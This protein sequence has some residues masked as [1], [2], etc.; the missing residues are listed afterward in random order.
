VDKPAPVGAGLG[1]VVGMEGAGEIATAPAVSGLE[2]GRVIARGATSEVWEGVRESDGRRVAVKVARADTESVEAAVR[3]ASLTAA[4]ASAHV[5]PVEACLPCDDGRVALVMPLLRGG[6]LGM[7]VAARGF[8]TA[9][10]VVTVLAPVAGALGRLH[11]VGVVHGDVSPGNVL[12][13]LDGRPSLADLGLARV[14][15]DE[16]A[17]VWGTEGYLAPEV[18]MGADPSPSSD[19]Y[20]LGALGWLCLT[21]SPPGPPG[22]RPELAE[23]SRAGEEAM[24]LVDVLAAAVAAQPADRPEAAE[25][26]WLLYESVE[27]APLHL[28]VGEDDGS[29]VTYRLRAAASATP[30]TQAPR[31][32]GRHARVRDRPARAPR[33][34]AVL[35]LAAMVLAGAGVAVVVARAGTDTA[36]PLTATRAARIPDP[37]PS[38]SP[39]SAAPQGPRDVRAERAAPAEDPEAVLTSLAE[40]RARAWRAGDVGL[41]GAAD[42]PGSPAHARD[43]ASLGELE[44]AGLRYAGLRYHVEAAETVSTGARRAVLRTF[45]G[46]GAYEV[47]GAG[48]RTARTATPAEEVFVELWWTDVGWRVAGIGAPR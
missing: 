17:A 36:A 39:R 41:L 35:V 13:D 48:T 44:R 1:T 46:T 19:V 8:L 16:P 18:L 33:R 10:E 37:S 25:L 45:I 2:L 3:E 23:V 6:S 4:A 21:G 40:A 20:A 28:V 26:A 32:R 34:A 31:R 30:A 42:A 7:L 43:A 14:V 9:G 24:A 5:V 47:V 38:P 15:G 29:A 11:A 22:L 27:A 12:L